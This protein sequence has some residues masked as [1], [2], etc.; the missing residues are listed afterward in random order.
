MYIIHMCC[1]MGFQKISYPFLDLPP[2]KACSSATNQRR[3]FGQDTWEQ[4]V[5][6]PQKVENLMRLVAWNTAKSNGFKRF[7]QYTGLDL[8]LGRCVFIA[9]SAFH[10][11]E[12]RVLGTW[13]KRTV[14]D[15][16][17]WDC[18]PETLSRME[19]HAWA[20][21]FLLTQNYNKWVKIRIVFIL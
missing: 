2:K 5:S 21:T 6:W 20:L 14:L 11:W 18:P 7:C 4:R 17:W 15:F 19:H 3:F 9:N 1:T 16:V 8:N 13:E 10:P 12:K